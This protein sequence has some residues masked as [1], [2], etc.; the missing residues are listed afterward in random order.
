[1]LNKVVIY[2]P[3]QSLKLRQTV[4]LFMGC[5]QRLN[6]TAHTLRISVDF[7]YKIEHQ[8]YV[9]NTYVCHNGN[10]CGIVTIGSPIQ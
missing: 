7:S 2:L 1:M 4:H 8:K 10:S 3:T 6:T 5:K 9:I